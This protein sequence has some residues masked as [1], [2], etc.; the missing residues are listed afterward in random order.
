[1]NQMFHSI[2]ENAGLATYKTWVVFSGQ[3]DMGWL[4]FL[5]PGFR[6]CFLLL[7]D[8]RQWLTVDPMLNHLDVLVHHHVAPDFDLPHWLATQGQTVMPAK[9][10]RMKMY[11]APLAFFTCVE[12]VKR[13]LGLHKLSI[14]TPW[15]LY[16]FLEKQTQNHN[17]G[18]ELW[19]H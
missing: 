1:M 3:T 12:A 11:P 8:G 16:R 14:I 7:H 17:K 19:D 5:K 13:Y 4:K 10:C 15:Q 6:H 2:Q 18:D 9:A